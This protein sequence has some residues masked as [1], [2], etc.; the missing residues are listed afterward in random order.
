MNRFQNMSAAEIS[1]LAML[2]PNQVT[3]VAFL[4][5]VSYKSQMY[6]LENEEVGNLLKIIHQIGGVIRRDDLISIYFDNNKNKYTFIKKMINFNLLKI[7]GSRNAVLGLTSTSLSIIEKKVVKNSTKISSATSNQLDIAAFL[8]NSIKN[9]NISILNKFDYCSRIIE[10]AIDSDYLT[11]ERCEKMHNLQLVLER[12]FDKL[13]NNNIY[14][15]RNIGNLAPSYLLIYSLTQSDLQLK[16]DAFRTISSSPK[17]QGL[18]LPK[19]MLEG[20]ENELPKFIDTIREHEVITENT[21]IE[22]I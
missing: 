22:F 20:K 1:R 8:L 14:I 10:Y 15:I 16:L 13:M 17:I 6:V 19:K 18:I 7:E 4:E 9:K 21:K 12:S 2:S 3:W 5:N 11:E